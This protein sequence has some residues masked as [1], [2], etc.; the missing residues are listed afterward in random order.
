M[1]TGKIKDDAKRIFRVISRNEELIF[2]VII[3]IEVSVYFYFF[4]KM[5]I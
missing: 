3:V 2:L 5:S 4:A 1:F